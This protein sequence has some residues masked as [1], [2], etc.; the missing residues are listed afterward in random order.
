METDENV[1]VD[2]P[3]FR[4]QTEE[5]LDALIQ[6]GLDLIGILDEKG[7]YKYTSPSV[8]SVLGYEED[9]LINQSAFSFIHP[10]DLINVNNQ[11]SKIL[12]GEE[13]KISNFRFRHADG[14]WRWIDTVATNLLNNSAVNGIVV[15]SRDV[16]ERKEKEEERELIIAELTR[17]NNDLKQFSFITSHNLKAPLSNIQGLLRLIN[18]GNLD[19]DTKEIFG[20]IEASTRKLT[21]I[22]NDI[23]KILLLKNNVNVSI[24]YVNI[25]SVFSEV[26][27]IFFTEENNISATIR[28]NFKVEKIYYN[29]IFLESIFTNLISNAIKY[30]SPHRTLAIDVSTCIDDSGNVV[31]RFSDN[32]VGIDLALHKNRIFGMYQRFHQNIEEGTGLGLFIIK[33]QIEAQGGKIVIESE[34]NKGS[35][36]YITFANTHST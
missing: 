36:F 24:D 5:R 34:V 28:T 26:N 13:T 27:D 23:S 31:L 32:G 7:I 15:N 10:D 12:T 33:S 4:S 9:Y 17:F 3:Q 8:K 18:P 6:N 22:I 29:K 20:L 30:R 11:F 16:T 35:T 14:S 21:E 2:L 19:T 25:K 1:N